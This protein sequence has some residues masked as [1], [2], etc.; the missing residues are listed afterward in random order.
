M[1]NIPKL[2][3]GGI[4]TPTPNFFI[5]DTHGDRDI[6]PCCKPIDKY[7]VIYNRTKKARIKKKAAKSSWILA[8]KKEL[9]KPIIIK[10]G[11]EDNES[12]T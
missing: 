6:I 4:I 3:K 9:E 1:F 7:Y 11:G 8:L 12:K 2:A 10:I 5:S